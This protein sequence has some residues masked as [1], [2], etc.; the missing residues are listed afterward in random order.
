MKIASKAGHVNV[1]H[2]DC[3]FGVLKSQK[4]YDVL[5]KRDC[6]DLHA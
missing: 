5:L 6:T 3:L 4:T 2:F 1:H